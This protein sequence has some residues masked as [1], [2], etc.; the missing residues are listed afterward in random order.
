VDD[1]PALLLALSGTLQNRLDHCIVD[2]CESGMQALDCVKARTYATIVSDVT[3]PDM[4]GWQ[5]LRAVKESKVETPVF[6]MS[7]NPS[8][9]VMKEALAAGAMDFLAKPFDRDDFVAMVRQGMELFGLNRMIALEESLIRRAHSHHATL[10]EKL[11]QHDGAYAMLDIH[12]AMPEHSRPV[13]Q[14]WK[15]RAQYRSTVVRHMAR[16]DKFLLKLAELH[17]GTSGRLC[18]LQ[19]TIRRHALTRVQ[20]RY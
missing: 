17:R 3:M 15:R 12:T 11:H 1:D 13:G 19:G 14:A 5:F 18:V 8:P 20:D 6:L 16:L 10:V 7:G 9:V 4:D 2:A